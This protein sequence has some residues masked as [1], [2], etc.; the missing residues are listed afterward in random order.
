MMVVVHQDLRPGET[1]VLDATTRE[2]VRQALERAP[3]PGPESPQF[4]QWEQVVR[5]EA[6]VDPVRPDEG[7]WLAAFAPV[8]S[9]DYVAIVQTRDAAVFAPT[10]MLLEQL[11]LWSGL[12]ALTGGALLVLSLWLVLRRARRRH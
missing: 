5:S 9:T 1:R 4:P 3:R 2:R 7:P 6:H 10:R 12:P 8:G 11:V